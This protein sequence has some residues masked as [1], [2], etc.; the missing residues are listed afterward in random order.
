MKL[1]DEKFKV[2]DHTK[3]G[4]EGSMIKASSDPKLVS[5]GVGK[6]QD[7]SELS[8]HV[9]LMEGREH[10]VDMSGVSQHK[11]GENETPAAVNGEV[12]AD[13]GLATG[14]ELKKIPTVHRTSPL[15]KNVT[16]A[17]KPVESQNANTANNSP[18]RPESP[19]KSEAKPD[20]AIA[21]TVNVEPV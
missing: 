8:V 12:K 19:E 20:V 14:G 21:K 15:A 1:M 11:E 5:N 2:F 6:K 7:P 18:S 16:N 17:E 9:D 10:E 3:L 4:R 13:S